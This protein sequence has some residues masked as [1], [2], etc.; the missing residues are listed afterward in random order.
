VSELLLLDQIAACLWDLRAQCEQQLR[1]L[2]NVHRLLDDYR[3]TG[4]HRL[5]AKRQLLLNVELVG[6]TSHHVS[7][8]AEHCLGLLE[9][10]P[11]AERDPHGDGN[12]TLEG[13]LKPN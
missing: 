9:Q 10:L 11:A 3:P 6:S 2:T 1:A 13:A 7:E 4:E 5:E 12:P 8:A